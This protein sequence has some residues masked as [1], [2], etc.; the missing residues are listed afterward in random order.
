MG[1][2]GFRLTHCR[3]DK[4][5]SVK[6]VIL[7]LDPGIQTVFNFNTK[8]TNIIIENAWNRIRTC[9]MSSSALPDI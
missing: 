6:I 5:Q 1:P 7:G 8:D 9:A 3:N 2:T 4:K